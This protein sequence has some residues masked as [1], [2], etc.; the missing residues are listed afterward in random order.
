MAAPTADLAPRL[1]DL[2]LDAS[3]ML[4]D[5]SEYFNSDRQDVAIITPDGST[6]EQ[7]AEP[8]ATDCTSLPDSFQT[9]AR[10]T[11]SQ[12]GRPQASQEPLDCLAMEF[13][14]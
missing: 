10:A 13:V 11:A 8:L 3:G 7:D 2:Q 6:D 14:S 4:V 12:A 5:E 9:Y 1:E